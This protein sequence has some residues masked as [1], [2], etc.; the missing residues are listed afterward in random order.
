MS[1]LEGMFPRVKLERK[2]Y[3]KRIVSANGEQIRGLG[4]KAVL[5]KK[6][7]DAQRSEL[8]VLSNLS[9]QCR[10]FCECSNNVRTTSNLQLSERRQTSEPYEQCCFEKWSRRTVD[11]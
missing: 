6:F 5:F 10:Q 9:F 3:P 2:I 1:C 4:E 7:K 8:Q 11:N